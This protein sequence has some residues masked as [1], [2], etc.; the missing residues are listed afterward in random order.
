MRMAPVVVIL[1]S[2]LGACAAGPKPSLDQ[3]K[4]VCTALIGPIKYNT[5]NSKSHRFAGDQLATDLA[6]RNRVGQ[7]LG[8]PAYR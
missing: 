5:Y 2:T 8:C 3:I 6:A 7:Y 4:P 1:A